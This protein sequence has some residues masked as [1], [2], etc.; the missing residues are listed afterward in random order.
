MEEKRRKAG[1][2][3]WRAQGKGSSYNSKEEGV[4]SKG[5]CLG[6]KKEKKHIG[7]GERI[8]V[9]GWKREG[10]KGRGSSKET[11]VPH[12]LVNGGEK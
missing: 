10:R 7:G 5:L 8:H 3:K 6:L 11:D 2:E 12:S 1:R 9:R 4:L